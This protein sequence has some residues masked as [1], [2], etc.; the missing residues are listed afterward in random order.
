MIIIPKKIF[1][2][3]TICGLLYS[4][5]AKAQQEVLSEEVD[6][7]LINH[8]KWGPNNAHYVNFYSQYGIP[9]GN[10]DQRLPVMANLNSPSAG[11][12]IYYKRKISGLLSIGL[13]L[14]YH[15]SE[16]RLKQ[17]DGYTITDSLFWQQDVAHKKERFFIN[18]IPARA[19]LRIN[20]DPRRGNYLGKF[21][22]VGGGYDWN[23]IK[24]Y[25][26][27]DVRRDKIKV[28]TKFTRLP[29]VSTLPAY[30]YARLGANTLSLS[31]EYR[32]TPYFKDSYNLPDLPPY[33]LN[34]IFTGK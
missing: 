19:F 6:T 16:M 2:I 4:N 9:L 27:Q 13:S 21:L 30:A 15:Y 8:K 25:E 12:G 34:V 31:F 14:G 7:S 28:K 3:S 17:E 26:T 24:G 11:V 5:G 29:Y 22:E 23:F 33:M 32:L 20:F 18:S 10:S 1:I